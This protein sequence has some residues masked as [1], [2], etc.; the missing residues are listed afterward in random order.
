[1]VEALI[2]RHKIRAI[3]LNMSQ[4]FDTIWHPAL[5]SKLST[6]GIQGQLHSWIADFLHSHSQ[7]VALNGTLSSP[8]P[9]KAGVPQGSVVGH[10][11]FVIFINV[12]TDSLENPP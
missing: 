8:L 11:L 1:M 5:L 10:I 12:L 4:P 2:I 9:A 6:N 3:S 7:Q